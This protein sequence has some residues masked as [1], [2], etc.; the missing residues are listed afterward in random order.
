[1]RRA[2]SSK[3]ML[4]LQGASYTDVSSLADEDEAQHHLK[5][6]MGAPQAVAFSNPFSQRHRSAGRDLK[7]APTTGTQRFPPK[8][9]AA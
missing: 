1:M 5:A 4:A 7:R 2:I 8:N 3:S 6:N 9:G